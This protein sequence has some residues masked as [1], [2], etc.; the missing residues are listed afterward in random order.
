MKIKATIE[1]DGTTFSR[2]VS[3]AET[4][5]CFAPI[6]AVSAVQEALNDAGLMEQGETL[7]V[8]GSDEATLLSKSEY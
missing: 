3:I 7:E 5:T 8:L 1:V 4:A 2:E 6:L